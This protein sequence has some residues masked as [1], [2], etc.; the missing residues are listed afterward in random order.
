M[1]RCARRAHA[2]PQTADVKDDPAGCSRRGRDDAPG[3]QR[4]RGRTSRIVRTRWA[5]RSQQERRRPKQVRRQRSRRCR[6]P[7]GGRWLPRRSP[8]M[9]M[10]FYTDQVASKYI[11]VEQD[12]IALSVEQTND[13]V[14]EQRHRQYQAA[15]R[16]QP[17]NRLRRVRRRAFRSPLSHG[18]RRR[19][20]RACA[21]CA[22]RSAPMSWRCSSM[23]PRVAAFPR[24][25]PP[26]P[27]RRLWSCTTRAPR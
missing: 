13:V 22:T 3:C 9:C 5:A 8:S 10:V 7:S 11:D 4:H 21:R 2:G 14:H 25:S 19:V 23:T 20:S 12:L 27:M 15:P 6:W 18:R 24:G 1:A 17:S 26:T 16:A